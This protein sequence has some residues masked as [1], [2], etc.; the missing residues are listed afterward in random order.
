MAIFQLR[1]KAL[2]ISAHQSS[3]AGWIQVAHPQL[4]T[5]QLN[6]K[7]HLQCGWKDGTIESENFHKKKIYSHKFQIF[8]LTSTIP[9]FKNFISIREDAYCVHIFSHC[10]RH[11]QI[12]RVLNIMSVTYILEASSDQFK[13]KIKLFSW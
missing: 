5:S 3:Q 12:F 1:L 7:A 9:T 13:L 4:C 10:S 11:N 8:S 2:S 6:S